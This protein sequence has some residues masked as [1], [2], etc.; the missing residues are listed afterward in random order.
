MFYAQLVRFGKVGRSSLY[1][2]SGATAEL[3]SV[4][5]TAVVGG[6]P[7]ARM[8]VKVA[9]DHQPFHILNKTGVH[10][11]K[12]SLMLKR[13]HVHACKTP[14]PRTKSPGKPR[15]YWANMMNSRPSASETLAM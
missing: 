10:G 8:Y 1:A 4:E 11:E 2:A 13:Q 5:T 15:Y 7:G 12:G 9:R 6:R 14:M 3:I